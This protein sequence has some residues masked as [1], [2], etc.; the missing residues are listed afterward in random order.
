LTVSPP[1]P[2]VAGSEG[3]GDDR[4][5][6]MLSR[7]ATGRV[8]LVVDALPYVHPVRYALAGGH[9]LVGV[10]AQTL[11]AVMDDVILA[12]QADG[13][14]EDLGRRWNVLAVGP[15]SRA[16]S[17]RERCPDVLAGERFVFRLRPRLLSGGWL[18]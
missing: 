17:A 5:R 4:C 11:A 12:L 6:A 15:A 13:Y 2:A 18:G 10:S 14:D 7:S 3:F 16:E 8:A 9:I 1:D